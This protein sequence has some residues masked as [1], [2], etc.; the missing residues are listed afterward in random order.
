MNAGNRQRPLSTFMT[1][2]L[3]VGLAAL[4]AGCGSDKPTQPGG[5]GASIGEYLNSLNYDGKAL[6]NYQETG[7]QDVSRTEESSDT[8]TEEIPGGGSKVCQETTYS[9]KQN[10]DRV[11]VLRPTNG[12]IYPGALVKANQGMMDGLPEPVTLPRAPLTLSIDLPGMGQNGIVPVANPTNSNVQAAMDDALEWWN[13]NAYQ[14]GY[15][16]AANSTYNYT[17]S[18]SSEQTALDIGLNMQ[19]AT[20]DFAGKFQS[21]TSA[22][23]TVVSASFQQ[24]FYTVTLDTPPEPED[25][26]ASSVSLEQVKSE[27][28][29]QAP[30]AYVS[31]VVYGRI[32]VFRM[33]N[34]HSTSAA[35][36]EAAFNYGVGRISAGGDLA[37]SYNKI[38]SESQVE[39]ITIGGNAAVASKLVDPSTLQE[40]IQGEN[41]VYSRSNPGVPIAYT[42]KFLKD[43]TNAKL[44]Y[45][46]EYTSKDCDFANQE[47]TLT[48]DRIKIV[49]DCDPWPLGPGEFSW[50]MKVY[51][52][53]GS[54]IKSASGSASA[55]DGESLSGVPNPHVF[56]LPATDGQS[57]KVTF[58]VSEWDTDILGNNFRDSQMNNRS[59]S[60]THYF[61]D[62]AWT[63][64]SRT[65]TLGVTG[66]K[67]ECQYRFTNRGV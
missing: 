9:L 6:L 64:T 63:N 4:I 46:T 12:V 51:N 36:L 40:V 59:G 38:L 37:A 48:I 32:I 47:V 54:T 1:G 15:V 41:A 49:D 67:V 50:S 8:T 62:G 28:D 2:A 44:G 16:N 17:S 33:E 22:Q 56:T 30:P 65:I 10:F 52:A 20:G 5:D 21:F 61:R 55:N 42:V 43:H 66:C 13:A 3:A 57:F 14:D 7:G 45:T 24:A 58:W 39:V 35:D 29:S 34:T 11:A 23:K 27:L 26:F 19:W 31:S 60:Y 25:V 53:G 18:Y